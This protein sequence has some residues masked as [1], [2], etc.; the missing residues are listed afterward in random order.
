MVRGLREAT[1]LGKKWGG[2]SGGITATM[3]PLRSSSSDRGATLMEFAIIFPLLVFLLVGIVES[4]WLFAQF[5]DVRHGAREGVRMA[6]VN[7][8]EGDDPPALVRT[9]ANT[10]A[11]LSETCDR[12]SVV[13]GAAVTFSSTGVVDDPI[14]VTATAPANTLSGLLDWAFPSSMSFT[15]TV[16]LHTE[17]E[18]TWDNT[19]ASTYPSGQPCP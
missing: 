19:D 6:T 11:L 17:Q 15:S 12:M 16:V 2:D 14:T 4:G 13:S 3:C 1:A 7:F 10:T 18:A 9:Q 8:P 5:L